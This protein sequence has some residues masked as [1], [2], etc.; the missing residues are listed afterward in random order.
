MIFL[1]VRGTANEKN[2]TNLS[3]HSQRKFYALLSF[4][5]HC[6]SQIISLIYVLTE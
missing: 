5:S 4:Y 6:F 1:V 2:I 3:K